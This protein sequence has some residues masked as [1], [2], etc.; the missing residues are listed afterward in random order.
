[1]STIIRFLKRIYVFIFNKFK[2]FRSLL[3]NNS[4]FSLY[5]FFS[6]NT[7]VINLILYTFVGII[8]YFF[9][10]DL[11]SIKVIKIFIFTLI[12][13]AVSMYILD[14]YT[15]SNNI[16]IKILQK[17]VFL[18]F[19]LSLIVFILEILDLSTSIKSF[20]DSIIG[21][22]NNLVL[23]FNLQEYYS[24]LDSLTLTQELALM[25][26]LVFIFLLLCMLSILSI[27]FGNELIKYLNLEVRFPWLSNLIKL[28]STLQ[29]YYLMWN[30]FIMIIFIIA[31]MYINILSLLYA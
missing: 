10:Y 15:F 31:P 22:G 17:L 20:I 28:R 6:N 21:R 14:N 7:K 11:T 9:L 2:D 24:F 30:I 3:L 8:S 16:F 1:M 29:R 26:L 19:K 18:I 5:K 12:S 13:L 23:D 4:Y 25:H 27:F